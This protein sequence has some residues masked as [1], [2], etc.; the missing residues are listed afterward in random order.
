[1]SDNIKRR[2]NSDNTE[3]V[4]LTPAEIQFIK[5]MGAI[6][7]RTLDELQ[8]HFGTEYLRQVAVQRFEYNL[9]DALE[10]KLELDRYNKNLTIIKHNSEK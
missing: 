4:D 5:N 2:I 3:V 7:Q 1:M 10:F 8:N 6:F 9:N